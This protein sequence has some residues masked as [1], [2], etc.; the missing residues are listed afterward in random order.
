VTAK[1]R[2]AK[3]A[4]KRPAKKRH[5]RG[6][7]AGRDTANAIVQARADM[8]APAVVPVVVPAVRG[9][10]MCK[11]VEAMDWR[12]IIGEEADAKVE[13]LA[14]SVQELRADDG[15]SWA[16]LLAAAEIPFLA[17]SILRDSEP[18]ADVLWRAWQR[19]YAA[20]QA[21]LAIGII[22]ASG[23]ASPMGADW[24]RLQFTVR[25]WLAERHDPET[26]G[27]KQQINKNVR[28]DERR[29]TEIIIREEKPS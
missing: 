1:K 16:E 21:G 26:Y 12:T 11:A 8:L 24:E 19:H 5:P 22:T 28:T 23:P 6:S 4:A 17:W 27:A 15:R 14:M 9:Y 29:V 25:R 7:L 2:P 10:W 20:V 18:I 13:A 3:K